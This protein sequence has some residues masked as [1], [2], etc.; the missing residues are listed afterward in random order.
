MT[1]DEPTILAFTDHMYVDGVKW[2]LTV[3]QGVSDEDI[4]GIFGAIRLA[5]DSAESYGFT[6][7]AASGKRTAPPATGDGEENGP[8]YTS[9]GVEGLPGVTV[10]AVPAAPTGEE[11]SWRRL[12]DRVEAKGNKVEMYVANPRLKF[13][14]TFSAPFVE[15][16][17]KARYGPNATVPFLLKR[18]GEGTEIVVQWRYSDKATE[19][20]NPYRD[21]VDIWTRDDYR[22]NVPQPI[23]TSEPEE[24]EEVDANGPF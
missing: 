24:E 7:G 5:H 14:V 11:T 22:E 4:A 16:I 9:Q 1:H 21:L 13:P 2:A 3:R 18:M 23:A 8:A 15:K 6:F 12:V 19:A 17:L 20:G 10:D